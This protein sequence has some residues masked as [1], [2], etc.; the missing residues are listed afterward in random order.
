MRIPPPASTLPADRLRQALKEMSTRPCIPLGRNRPAPIPH[1]EVLFW[2]R[3][4]IE[5][6]FAE[7][8]D[9]QQVYHAPRKLSGGVPFR[10]HIYRNR[11]VLVMGAD[12]WC[13]IR[14]R[15]LMISELE[16]VLAVVGTGVAFIGRTY[17]G[18][19][20]CPP[21]R[22]CGSSEGDAP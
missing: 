21:R 12:P 1:D 8:M 13:R 7:L 16:I 17:H 22:D 3:H 20:R 5:H 19:E 18:A 4:V 14:V 2:K 10:L 6:S 9:W 11:R 15:Q